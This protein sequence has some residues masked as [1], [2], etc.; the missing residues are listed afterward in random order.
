MH[1]KRISGQ[2]FFN[3]LFKHSVYSVKQ[4]NNNTKQHFSTKQ[5]K[6]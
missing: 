4:H 2:H 5:T 1:K 3:A 6:S